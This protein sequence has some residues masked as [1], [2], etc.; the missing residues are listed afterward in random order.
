MRFCAFKIIFLIS[1]LL[2]HSQVTLANISRAKEYD[3]S[4]DVKKSQKQSNKYSTQGS[5]SNSW[6]L[7]MKASLLPDFLQGTGE[8]VYGNFGENTNNEFSD[9]D[10]YLLQLGVSGKRSVFGYGFNFYSVG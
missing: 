6:R 9:W 10:K 3:F 4:F 7:G 2:F 1:T 8:L 5:S